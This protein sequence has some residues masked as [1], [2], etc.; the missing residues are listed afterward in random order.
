LAADAACFQ[1]GHGTHFVGQPL[2]AVPRG[3]GR[4]KAASQEWLSYENLEFTHRQ[5][6]SNLYSET[7]S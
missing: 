6:K 7:N 5:A 3:V 4:M 1:E 2:L